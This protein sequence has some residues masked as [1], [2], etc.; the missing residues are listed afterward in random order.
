MSGRKV[1]ID[2]LFELSIVDEPRVDPAGRR[3]AFTVTTL[4][5]DS[6]KYAVA[7]LAP[8]RPTR[9]ARALHVWRSQGHRSAMV[10]RRVLVG[11]PF[12]P[13]IRRWR[14]RPPAVSNVGFAA[15]NQRGSRLRNTGWSRSTGHLMV[16]P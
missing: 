7:D 8:G 10:S 12:R 9:N 16:G 15:E 5:R 2:D 6:D 14:E 11:L 13:G 3:V 1:S 4:D